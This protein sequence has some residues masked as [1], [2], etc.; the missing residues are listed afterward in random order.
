M[1]FRTI[2][3][4]EIDLVAFSGR[5][6]D[7]VTIAFALSNICRYNGHVKR[8]YSVAEH[9]MNLARL[10]HPSNRPYALLHDACEAYLG[11][12]TAP[13][14]KLL[15]KYQAIERRFQDTIFKHFGLNTKIPNEV[16]TADV[17]I[18]QAEMAVL[19]NLENGS[20]L[21]DK[22]ETLSDIVKKITLYDKPYEPF[23]RELQEAL[24]Q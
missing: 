18:R 21:E 13:V 7:L 11:D 6:V 22:N 19:M 9:S 8:H 20:S 12:L 3:G 23:L 24:G 4:R 10:V 17:V 14:K 16:L 5:D 1:L 15:P 2:T